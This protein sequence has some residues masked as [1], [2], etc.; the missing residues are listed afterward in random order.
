MYKRLVV[1]CVSILTVGVI[2]VQAGLQDGLVAYFQLDEGSGTV[3][4]D[5]SGNGHDGVLFGNE[6]EWVPG[7]FGGAVLFSTAESEAHVEFPTTGMS[8]SA[9]TISLWGYL[10]EPQA[11]RTRYFFGH[12]TRPPYKDRIQIYMDGG[13]TNLDLGLGDAHARTTD[14]AVLRTKTWVHIVLTWDNGRYVVYLDGEK[15]AEGTY[16]GLTA[17]DPVAN[18]SDD[19]NPDENEAFDGVLDEVR[20][21]SRAITAA[22]VTEI[23]QAP[24]APRVKAWGPSPA[25]GAR[26]VVAPVLKWKSLDTIRLHDVYVGTDPNLTAANLVGP[27][28]GMNLYYYATPLEPGVVYYWRVDEIESDLVTIH[29]GDVWSFLAQPLTAYDPEPPDGTNTAGSSLDLTWRAGTGAMKHHVYFSDSLDAVTEGTADA[30]QGILT[31]PN[32]APGDL[33][34]ASTYFWRVDEVGLNDVVRTGAVWSFTTIV[35]VDDFES[36]NDEENQG[37]RIYETWLD[38]LTNNTGSTVGYWDPPFAEQTIVHGGLQSMPLDY[39]NVDP[40]FYSEAERE[41]APAEDWTALGTDT[42]VLYI[43]GRANNTPAPLY[44]AIEDASNRSV[45]VMDPNLAPLTATEWLEWRIRL[46]DFAGVNPAR[47]RKLIIGVGDEANPVAGGTG[48]LYV[49]DICLTKPA[50]ARD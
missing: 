39:N 32:F 48:L 1:I 47:V 3:A 30:D 10:S 44:V 23:F 14:I 24:A 2:P 19:D 7:R 4:A 49:D 33:Q 28:W 15:A 27:R 8:V 26:D 11:S 20:I 22:E 34:D 6:V 36:Y 35:P 21:Y 31:D 38:G 40:P 29:T 17:L 9:G 25:D 42:L 43:Q 5:S 16:T 50:P 41:F 46:S 37:T 18:I 12:T 45:V 13:N